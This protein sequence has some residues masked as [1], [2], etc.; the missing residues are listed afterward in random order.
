MTEDVAS[1]LGRALAFVLLWLV[2]WL[3]LIPLGML[4]AW[5]WT[6]LGLFP[7]DTATGMIVVAALLALA[8]G[9]TKGPAR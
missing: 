8:F 4:V 7:I 9:R 6:A 2:G 1:R 5:S 3:L